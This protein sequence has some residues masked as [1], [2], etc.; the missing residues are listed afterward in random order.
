MA[1]VCGPVTGHNARFTPRGLNI[2]KVKVIM[3][4]ALGIKDRTAARTLIFALQVLPDSHL[5]AALSA[6]NCRAI[7]FAA[8]PYFDRMSSQRIVAILAGIVFAATLHPDSDDIHG[9]V[10]MYAPGLRIHVDSVHC[11]ARMVHDYR[12]TNCGADFKH[13]R[14]MLIRERERYAPEPIQIREDA[15][16]F[17]GKCGTHLVL[18]RRERRQPHKGKWLL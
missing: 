3:I 13:I 14:R 2:L 17:T 8:R 9:Q 10:V 18:S 11:R 5:H 7:P 12:S 15:N 4:T 1:E 16:L 6:Q